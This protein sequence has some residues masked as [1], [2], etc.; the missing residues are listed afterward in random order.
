MPTMIYEGEISPDIVPLTIGYS[1]C[2]MRQETETAPEAEF[3]IEVFVGR[4]R[5]FVTTKVINQEVAIDLY[6]P[7]WDVA[8]TLIETYGFI[9]AVPYHVTLSRVILPSGQVMNVALAD[10]SLAQCHDFNKDDLEAISDIALTDLPVSLAISDI[11]MTLGKA[12]YSP[13]ACGRVADSIARLLLPNGDRKAQ[14]EAVRQNL[15]VDESFLRTLSEVSKGPR[16]GDRTEV[17]AE[18]NKATAHRAWT[19]LGRYLRYRIDGDQASERFELLT[20][21]NTA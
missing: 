7:A 5:V 11:L 1:P 21:E 6:L 12:H 3:R 16:H 17:F 10:S 19:L 15:R 2:V 13:T 14:W 18:E 4:V 8:R 9:A 20:A